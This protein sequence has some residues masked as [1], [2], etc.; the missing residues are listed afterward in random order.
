MRKRAFE[1]RITKV[2]GGGGYEARD[3]RFKE[4]I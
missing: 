4:T 1:G 3:D 2:I